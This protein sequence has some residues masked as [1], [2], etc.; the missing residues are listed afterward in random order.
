MRL[1]IDNTEHAATDGQVERHERWIRKAS[2]K[3]DIKY[4]SA[5]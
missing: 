5:A 2:S 4:D 3:L 1:E